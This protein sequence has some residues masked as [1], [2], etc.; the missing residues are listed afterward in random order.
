[1]KYSF[2][3]WH[4]TAKELPEPI[5]KTKGKATWTV[6]EPLL[7]I[8]NGRVKPSEYDSKSNTW[9]GHTEEQVPQ[10]WIK[11]SEIEILSED[12]NDS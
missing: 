9:L 12:D 6:N 8:W 11:L 7:V 5:V 3:E 4:E 1:M 10:Y 2:I